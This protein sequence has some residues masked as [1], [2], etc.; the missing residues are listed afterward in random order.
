MRRCKENEDKIE[1]SEQI[2]RNIAARKIAKAWKNRKPYLGLKGNS[3]VK[4]PFAGKFKVARSSG[5]IGIIT[6]EEWA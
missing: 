6:F 1:A 3:P 4:N 2:K 5:T